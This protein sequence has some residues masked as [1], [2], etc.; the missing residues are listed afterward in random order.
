[1]AKQGKTNA[2]T[3]M[4]WEK[5]WGQIAAKR[6]SHYL[7][8]TRHNARLASLAYAGRA[9]HWPGA[10]ILYWGVSVQGVDNICSRGKSG[11]FET[12]LLLLLIL[13]DSFTKC[14]ESSNP[15]KTWRVRQDLNLQPSDPKSEA[16]SN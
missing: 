16:L 3:E 8:D 10:G 12:P 9:F 1:M 14:G 2:E 13:L 15:N 4:A 7:P 5:V 6:E 11:R